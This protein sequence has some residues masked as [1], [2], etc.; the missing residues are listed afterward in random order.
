MPVYQEES[1]VFWLLPGDAMGLESHKISGVKVINIAEENDK[2]VEKMVNH[3]IAEI[4][5]QKIKILEIQ[6][7]GDNLILILGDKK[8]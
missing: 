1:G 3:A 2:A 7:T 4:N 5:K 8:E 6:T